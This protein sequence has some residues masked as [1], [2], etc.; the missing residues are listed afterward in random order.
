MNLSKND[1]TFSCDTGYPTDR[2]THSI[3]CNEQEAYDISGKGLSGLMCHRYSC[4][5]LDP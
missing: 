3:T 5:S 1:C 2:L 4:V